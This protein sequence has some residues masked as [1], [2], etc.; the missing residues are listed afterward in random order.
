MDTGFLCLQLYPLASSLWYSFTNYSGF[1]EAA[2][3]GLEN[4]KNIFR[5]DYNFGQSLKVTLLY[6]GI[7][8]PLKLMFALFIAML[9][10]V[11]LRGS[12]CI[13]DYLLYTVDSW[14][15]RGSGDFVA[16]LCL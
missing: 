8:V 3:I 5:F 1:G 6:V 7:T 16:F 2:F 12:E 15:K 13:S 10:S 9:L 4:Y 11:P 14:L